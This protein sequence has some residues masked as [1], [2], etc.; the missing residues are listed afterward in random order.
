M[1]KYKLR[2]ICRCGTI[3]PVCEMP[4]DVNELTTAIK[5]ARCPTCDEDSNLACIVVETRHGRGTGLPDS[6]SVE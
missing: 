3:Y 5:D 1:S 4:I 6:K 2:L